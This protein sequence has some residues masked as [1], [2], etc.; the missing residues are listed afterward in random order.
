MHEKRL[1]ILIN[2]AGITSAGDEASSAAKIEAVRGSLERSSWCRGDQGIRSE[3]FYRF[4]GSTGL[5]HRSKPTR[6]NQVT[7]RRGLSRPR[8]LLGGTLEA[9]GLALRA[10]HRG[11]IFQFELPINPGKG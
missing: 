3:Q 10:A 6:M 1:D 4:R 2:N 11:S 9:R 7:L 5:M 8:G